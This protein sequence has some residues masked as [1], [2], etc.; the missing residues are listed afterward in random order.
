MFDFSVNAWN[1]G[2][3]LNT[4]HKGLVS[5]DRETKKDAFYFYKANWSDH[6]TLY[7]AELRHTER[8]EATTE[9]KVYTNLTSKVTLELN[10]KKVASQKLESDLH[11][12]RFKDIKLRE[13]KNTIVVKAKDGKEIMQHFAIWNLTK[14]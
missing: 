7:I 13:G 1:R 9:V 3:T 12:I 2:G 11:I 6:P 5:F 4:N 8:T 14:K 10:G